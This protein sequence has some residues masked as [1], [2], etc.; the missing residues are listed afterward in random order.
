MQNAA[1][2][3]AFV[4]HCQF[5]LGAHCQQIIN[6][7]ITELHKITPAPAVFAGHLWRYRITIGIDSILEDY[8]IIART[9]SLPVHAA[10]QT[11]FTVFYDWQSSGYTVSINE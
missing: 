3:Q 9:T 8:Q 1:E 7:S 10:L 2:L 11:T 5:I 6:H 4:N